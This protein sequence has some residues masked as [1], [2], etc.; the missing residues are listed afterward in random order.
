[1]FFEW[2]YHTSGFLGWETHET[3][4]RVGFPGQDN[5]ECDI[6]TQRT[7]E[8]GAVEWV[9][10]AKETTSVIFSLKEHMSAVFCLSHATDKSIL[11][12]F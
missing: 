4:R 7:H 10:Q 8:C 11:R 9:S 12:H 2:K 5:H 3:A 6:S 1:V